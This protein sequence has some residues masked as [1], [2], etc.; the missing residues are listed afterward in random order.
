MCHG[1]TDTAD[2]DHNKE[3]DRKKGLTT[4]AVPNK[5]TGSEVDSDRSG[6][7]PKGFSRQRV[8]QMAV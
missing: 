8:M 4:R 7:A 3:G 1:W 2:G 5:S 6:K